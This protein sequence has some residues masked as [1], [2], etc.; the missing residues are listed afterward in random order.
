ME[1]SEQRGSCQ[2]LEQLCISTVFSVNK[3]TNENGAQ[4]RT[5]S[6]SGQ[7]ATATHNRNVLRY[8]SSMLSL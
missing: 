5:I 6:Q 7:G 4:G 1:T 3:S 2:A 8:Y